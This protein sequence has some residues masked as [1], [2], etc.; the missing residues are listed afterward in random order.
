[1]LSARSAAVAADVP[2]AVISTL[3]LTTTFQV[4]ALVI[5]DL[6]VEQRQRYL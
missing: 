5:C 3:L 1:M 4:L 6:R 2:V